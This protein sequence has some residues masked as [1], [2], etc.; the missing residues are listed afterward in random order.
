MN[1]VEKRNLSKEAQMQMD[2]LKKI[3]RWRTIAIALS[4]LGVAA[5]YAAAAG[6]THNLF[7]GIL[8]II[9]I[10]ISAGSAVIL[11]LGLKN[12]RRN[13]EKILN[14]LNNGNDIG[15]CHEL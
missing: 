3:S 9:I 8:G 13:V 1:A 15:E 11:N 2:A 7:L 4:T 5:I 12:G 14:V 6:T 10:L